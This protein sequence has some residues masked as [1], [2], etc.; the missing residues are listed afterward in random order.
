[1]R[2]V[3]GRYG[4]GACAARAGLVRVMWTF[5]LRPCAGVDSGN[6][7]RLDLQRTSR[8]QDGSSP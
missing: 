3:F 8:Q 6:A 4:H 2:K 5:I 1:M 7:D